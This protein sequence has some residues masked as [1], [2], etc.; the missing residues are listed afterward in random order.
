MDA[1]PPDW[2][3][4]IA[5][6]PG[7]VAVLAWFDAD[8]QPIAVRRIESAHAD[9]VDLPIRAILAEGIALDARAAMLAHNHPS[10][11]ARPSRDDI[12]ATRRLALALDLIDARL[13]DHWIV[14][15]TGS[16]SLRAMGLL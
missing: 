6:E 5:R 7:E 12:A 11:I 13:D 2:C 15:R 14:T 10:G 8:R 9:H 3:A 4:R 16:V 1:D